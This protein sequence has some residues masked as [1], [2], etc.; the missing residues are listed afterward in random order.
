MGLEPA[1]GLVPPAL[2][3]RSFPKSTEARD[4]FQSRT[5][6]SWSPPRGGSWEDLGA[7]WPGGRGCSLG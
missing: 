7:L 2:K 6:L 3:E 4:H 5:K 1:K